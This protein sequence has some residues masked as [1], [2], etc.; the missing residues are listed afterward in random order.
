MRNNQRA[1]VR[2]VCTHETN[3]GWFRIIEKI[4]NG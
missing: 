1:K 4:K 2:N 3:Q